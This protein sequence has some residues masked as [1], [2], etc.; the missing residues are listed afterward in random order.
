MQRNDLKYGEAVQ[1]KLGQTGVH[2]LARV[3]AANPEMDQIITI[4]KQLS[5]E[6]GRPKQ[7]EDPWSIRQE[8]MDCLFEH[9]LMGIAV[10]DANGRLLMAN[11]GFT[12]LT[13]Y[14]GKEIQTLDDWFS[15]A[16]PD[17]GYRE[18]VLKDWAS[19][20][21]Q[22]NAVRTF[23]VTCKSG[24]V[25]G[26]EF[27]GSFLCS[28]WALVMMT[29]VTDTHRSK[30]SLQK[31]TDRY[32][33]LS[34]AAFE[35]MFVSV[36]GRCIDTNQAAEKM[37]GYSREELIGIF[38]TDVIAPESKERVKRNMLSG[39]DKPYEALA[40]RKDGK[41]FHVEIRGQMTEHRGRRVRITVVHDIDQRKRAEKELKASESLLKSIFTSAPVGIGM[42]I[43][44]VISQ[45]NDRL[46][47]MLGYP[48]AELLNQGARVLYPTDADFE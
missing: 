4:A 35:A 1:A 14:T 20:T 17:A 24:Q 23:L 48:Q 29:D 13:G 42:V 31:Q 36:D 33:A 16:Y 34:N 2:D 22:P 15:R 46:C 47:E 45:A 37:F 44:R 19:S 25:K 11:R 3:L 40:Q 9:P 26:I 18:K 10:W 7:S 8:L 21:D 28:G 43:N 32:Q 27:R 39:Y 38:G 41:R 6:G 5:A 12:A 30:T